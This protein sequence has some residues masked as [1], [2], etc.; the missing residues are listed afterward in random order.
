MRTAWRVAMIV[1][2]AAGGLYAQVDPAVLRA[3]DAAIRAFH[4]SPSLGRFSDAGVAITE[5]T[6]WHTLDRPDPTPKNH[7]FELMKARLAAGVVVSKS[8]VPTPSRF[9]SP[10]SRVT[11][12]ML[13]R[14]SA[15]LF[16]P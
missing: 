11:L 12:A 5:A 4:D 15:V 3:R 10:T 14:R 1:L 7:E 8:I 2:T 16:P 9:S 6:G 13:P